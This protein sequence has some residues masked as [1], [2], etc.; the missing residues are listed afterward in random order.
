HD[1]DEIHAEAARQ[2]MLVQEYFPASAE[3]YY[4][5]ALV[6]Y[7][8]NALHPTLALLT[9]SH[10]IDGAF[11]PAHEL[12][13][14]VQSTVDSARG[15]GGAAPLLDARCSGPSPQLAAAMAVAFQRLDRDRDGVLGTA[16]LATMVKLTNGQPVPTAAIAQMIHAFGGQVRTASGRLCAGWD[17][18][19]LTR[20][21]VAQTIQDPNETRQDLA[22]L[23]F[24]PH[25]LRSHPARAA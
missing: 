22:K 16:E 15:A 3:C 7:M 2:L 11:A 4:L 17:L 23:G 25:T 21:Y 5:W 14:T 20:F 8:R 9:I 1:N 6:C 12:L 24:D 19:A 13:A 10:G 18:A